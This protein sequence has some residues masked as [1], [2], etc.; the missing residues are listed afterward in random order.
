[1]LCSKIARST[2]SLTDLKASRSRLLPTASMSIVLTDTDLAT[3]HI[4]PSQASL[5]GIPQELRNKIFEYVHGV[6]DP[7]GKRIKMGLLLS[8]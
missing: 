2:P 4:H 5:L 6:S 1:M 8:S 7:V 3:V